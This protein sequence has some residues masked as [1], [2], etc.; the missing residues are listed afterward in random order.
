M[1]IEDV[2]HILTTTRSVRRRLDLTRPVEPE[3]IQQCLEIA[4]Q[5]PTG[6][7]IPQYYFIVVTDSE[8]RANLADL[9]RKAFDDMFRTERLEDYRR[10]D[11][12]SWMFLYDHLHSVPVH[13]IPCA[14]GRPEGRSPERLAALYGNV[15]PA[16]WSLMLALRARGLGA[17]WTSVHISYEKEAMSLLGIP[18]TVTQ[19]G[20]LPV[21]YFT[22]SD[23]KPAKRPPA[24]ERTF[25]NTWNNKL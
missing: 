22:G 4:I 8:R 5:A 20:L 25:W 7:N 11:V 12:E 9:Y 1:A 17:A 16:A 19:V 10:R 21:A 24:R 18:E 13:I 3:V 14:E 6:A 23:F 15:L 2:N